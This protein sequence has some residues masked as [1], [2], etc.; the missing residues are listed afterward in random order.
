MAYISSSLKAAG[1]EVHILDLNAYYSPIIHIGMLEML[2]KRKIMEINPDI[3]ATGG[4]SAIYDQI[5]AVIGLTRRVN[6]RIISIIGG[7]CVSSEPELIMENIPAD[8]G[9]LGEGEIT[10][11]E[12]LEKIEAKSASFEEVNG[13][14]FRQ[15]SR[16]V[17][18]PARRPIDDLDSVPHPDYEGFDIQAYLDRQTLTDQ[19]IHPFNNLRVVEIAASRSCP[20]KCTFCF[21]PVGDKYRKRSINSVISEIEYLVTRYQVNYILLND[22]LFAGDK[23][24]LLEFC[25]RVKKFH[26]KWQAQLRVDIVDEE[27]ILLLKDSGCIYIS[28]GLESASPA[29]LKSMRKKITVEQ[30]ENALFLTKKHNILIQG[31]FI[32]GDQ[33]ETLETIV[34]TLSWWFKHREYRINL[35]H[36]I[37]YPGTALYHYAIEQGLIKQNRIDYIK[38]GC[39]GLKDLNLT[40]LPDPVFKMMLQII[41]GNLRPGNF[42]AGHIIDSELKGC[43]PYQGHVYS[44]RIRC[45]Y[46]NTADDYYP[47]HSK[48]VKMSLKTYNDFGFGCRHCN[49]RMT[50]LPPEA[51]TFL[52]D[53]VKN[54]YKKLLLLGADHKTEL[55]INTSHTLQNH[56]ELIVCEPGY[57]TK[58]IRHINV[59]P[60]SDMDIRVS[61]IDAAVHLFPLNA[62]YGGMAVILSSSGIPIFDGT[63]AFRFLYKS[64]NKEQ[65][66]QH[67]TRAAKQIDEKK[68]DNNYN[69]ANFL[70]L[71]LQETYPDIMD[72]HRNLLETSGMR[73]DYKLF[74]DVAYTLATLVQKGAFEP[75]KQLLINW[76]QHFLNSGDIMA[77]GRIKDL[78]EYQDP[79]GNQGLLQ[80]LSNA[81][82]A[83]V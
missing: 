46:C 63:E 72:I 54:G 76:F 11:V 20:F 5:H 13:I 47:I 34:E 45:P 43:D 30:I 56:V 53:I 59:K 41:L 78:F 42:E 4:L 64:E 22:E 48:Y 74:F 61:E 23:K 33:A 80:T 21:H 25:A 44:L 50:F 24:W 29:I 36:L 39:K 19:D 15:G 10:I 6:N 82:R 67:L 83:K 40:T 52:M 3:V 16:L 32:F 68:K 81:L 65:I 69:E 1:H 26:V 71:E 28:Y 49:Q 66:Q 62:T 7:G 12:L 37:P 58:Q 17:T 31:N 79:Q 55:I 70:L 73:K 9:V 14:I 2:L 60:V 18:T 57:G 51:E 75:V 77:A 27:L 8:F 35:S 38:N